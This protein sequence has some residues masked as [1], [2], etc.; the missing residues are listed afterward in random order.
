GLRKDINHELTILKPSSL[1][2]GID[3][4]K[5]AEA[6][7][8]AAKPPFS[9]T[10]K[11][12]LSSPNPQ[13]SLLGPPLPVPIRRLTQAEQ[14]KRRSKGLCFNCDEK[15]HLGHRC[16]KKQFLLLL[17]DDPDEEV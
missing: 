9:R 6:K 12:F 11:S 17:M 7:N 4:A 5:L 1:T 3:L 8:L 10:A 15:F 16:A 2:Q 14:L 13:P